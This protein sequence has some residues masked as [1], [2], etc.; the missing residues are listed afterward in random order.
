MCETAE[1]K[2]SLFPSFTATNQWFVPAVKGEVPAGCA[3][4]GIVCD[5]TKIYLFGGMVEYGR[6]VF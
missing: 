2:E 4:Y 6:F 1:S 5:G 3:A